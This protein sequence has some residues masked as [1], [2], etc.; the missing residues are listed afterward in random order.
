MTYTTHTYKQRYQV[1]GRPLNGDDGRIGQITR[2]KRL[3]INVNFSY[4][5]PL[6]KTFMC[7]SY[8]T[9]LT[10]WVG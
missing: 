5:K 9:D 1:A 7:E 3:R 2:C 4:N 10:D 6:R 8:Q